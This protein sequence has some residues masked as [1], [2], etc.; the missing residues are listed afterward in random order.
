[1]QTSFETKL[2]LMLQALIFVLFGKDNITVV[3]KTIDK[4]T[5]LHYNGFTEQKQ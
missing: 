1:M 4:S 2:N 5:L 3:D